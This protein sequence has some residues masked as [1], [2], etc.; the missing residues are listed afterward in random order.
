MS[1][2]YARDDAEVDDLAAD[3]LERFPVLAVMPIAALEADGFEVVPTFRTP[4]V[5]IA[6][7]GDPAERLDAL[8]ALVSRVVENPYHDREPN[9]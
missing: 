6:F 7:T 3:Q 5:T 4:H 9:A 8:A 2:Y 1:A